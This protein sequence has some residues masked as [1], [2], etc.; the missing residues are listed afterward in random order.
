MGM[1]R[2]PVVAAAV[3]SVTV[4]IASLAFAA[5]IDL[6]DRPYFSIFVVCLR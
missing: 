4:E 6:S 3:D 1:R 5:Y 2:A